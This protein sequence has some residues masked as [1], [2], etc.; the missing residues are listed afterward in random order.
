MILFKHIVLIAIGIAN[1]SALDNVHLND[2]VTSIV[3]EA[4]RTT[5]LRGVVTDTTAI[6]DDSDM[7]NEQDVGWLEAAHR[8]LAKKKPKKNK[9][10]N[11][12]KSKNK[13]NNNG[14]G[15]NTREECTGRGNKKWC[16]N[17]WQPHDGN[18]KWANKKCSKQRADCSDRG[19]V[20]WCTNDVSAMEMC[21]CDMI[22][23][24]LT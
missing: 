16:L 8:M 3:E 17:E 21:V 10:K 15:A 2:E 9:N 22:C 23:S 20:N 6:L 5:N 1:V 7:D 19:N 12:N 11:K 4:P 18:C 14:G 13:N 24:Y